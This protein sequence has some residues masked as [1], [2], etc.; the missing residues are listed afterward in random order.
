MASPDVKVQ[1]FTQAIGSN[2]NVLDDMLGSAGRCDQQYGP[3]WYVRGRPYHLRS[4]DRPFS[5]LGLETRVDCRYCD[6]KLV[7]ETL[8]LKKVHSSAPRMLQAATIASEFSE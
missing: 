8:R 3:S 5:K 7:Q 6:S 1:K 4:A 2:K